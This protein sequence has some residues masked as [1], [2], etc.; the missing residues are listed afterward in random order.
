MARGEMLTVFTYDVSSNKRRRRVAR[1]LEDAASRVQ[2][3]VFE[4]RMTRQ[5]AAAVSQ[6]VAAELDGTDS[7]R[8]YAIGRNGERRTRTYGQAVPIEP[9]GDFWLL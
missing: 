2:Y 4:G 5:K 8:V 6:R 9:A 3:S 1:I 7:L